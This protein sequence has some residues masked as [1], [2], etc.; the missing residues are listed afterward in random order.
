MG[1]GAAVWS[2]D[3]ELPSSLAA[4]T[5]TAVS[6]LMGKTEWDASLHTLARKFLGCN[7]S[8]PGLLPFAQE[9]LPVRL[10][11]QSMQLVTMHKVSC[12]KPSI[13]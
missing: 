11:M 13:R 7:G 2:S 1:L 6:L 4:I 12:D 9:H 5:Q 8:H 3:P 10:I